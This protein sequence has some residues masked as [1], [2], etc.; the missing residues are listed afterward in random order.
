MN[1]ILVEPPGTAPGSEPSI[2][3]AFIAIVPVA[4]DRVNIGPHPSR[5]KGVEMKTPGTGPGVSQVERGDQKPALMFS[6]SFT[7]RSRSDWS[8]GV[9]ARSVVLIGSTLAAFS[10]SGSMVFMPSISV[11]A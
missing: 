10:A 6:N 7:M 3:G 8:S 4:R 9:C 1:G 2:T 5:C 11:V